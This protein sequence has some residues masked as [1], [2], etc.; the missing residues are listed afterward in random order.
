MALPA[1]SSCFPPR[2]QHDRTRR[3]MIYHKQRC[4]PSGFFSKL[5]AEEFEILLKLNQ[6]GLSH[7]TVAG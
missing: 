3:E 2:H 6:C 5:Y 4:F 1:E 7:Q